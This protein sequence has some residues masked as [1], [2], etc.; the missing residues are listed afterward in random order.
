MQ[1]ALRHIDDFLPAH[2]LASLENLAEQLRSL[3]ARPRIRDRRPSQSLP[4]ERR[5]RS[6]RGM[7]GARLNT[8]GDTAS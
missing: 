7:N 8:D 6:E 1:A 3:S 4:R 2:N 5:Y